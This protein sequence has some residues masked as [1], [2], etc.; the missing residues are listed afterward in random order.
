[1][2]DSVLGRIRNGLRPDLDL[3]TGS[4]QVLGRGRLVLA[5]DVGNERL[6][7]GGRRRAERDV[8]QHLGAALGG[9]PRLRELGD[10]GALRR[11]VRNTLERRDEPGLADRPASHEKLMP[12][13]SGTETEAG[14]A[15]AGWAVADRRARSFRSRRSA[16]R[17]SRRRQLCP[18]PDAGQR[19]GPKAGRSAPWA[20]SGTRPCAF[21]VLTAAASSC[22][23]TSGIGTGFCPFETS[24]LTTE[25]FGSV[26][27][28]AGSCATTTFR[29]FVENTPRV[30][31]AARACSSC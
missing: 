2:H 10:D 14:F 3:V 21:T 9:R 28:A 8:H 6:G 30:V 1:M 13:S 26:D 7:A 23:T 12:V 25:P 24:S 16:A 17:R 20:T 5:G 4:S 29:G 15:G 22:P 11:V 19:P 31:P 18:R 27:P